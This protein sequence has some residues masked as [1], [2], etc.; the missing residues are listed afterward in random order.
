MDFDIPP[1]IFCEKISLGGDRK[2]RT[3]KVIEQ[4]SES[5][6]F[7]ID[8]QIL[9]GEG[10]RHKASGFHVIFVNISEFHSSSCMR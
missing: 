2:T 8:N 1:S 9:G 6:A 10:S 5:S 3:Q 4:E 7:S